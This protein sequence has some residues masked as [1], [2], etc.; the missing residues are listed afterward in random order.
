MKIVPIVSESGNRGNLWIDANDLNIYVRNKHNVLPNNIS[1]VN[2]INVINE[3]F[4]I[5]NP[6]SQLH[7]DLADI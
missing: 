6:S 4:A 7:A 5:V 3:Y 2:V 1:D